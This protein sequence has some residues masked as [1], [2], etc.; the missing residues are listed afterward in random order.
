M[1]I[2]YKDGSFSENMSIQEA[3]EKFK[4]DLAE[5]TARSLIAGTE[6]ELNQVKRKKSVED[7]IDELTERLEAVERGT[8]VPDIVSIPTQDE[9]IHV[10]KGDFSKLFK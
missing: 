6:N 1:A 3:M 2:Q 8:I 5:G 4:L 10:T 7:K 9:I